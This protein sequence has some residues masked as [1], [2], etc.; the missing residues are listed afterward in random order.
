ML[1]ATYQDVYYREDEYNDEPKY[2]TDHGN[3]FMQWAK[4]CP[5]EAERGT[6]KILDFRRKLKEALQKQ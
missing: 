5:V 3:P 4:I 1:S 2:Q 6:K